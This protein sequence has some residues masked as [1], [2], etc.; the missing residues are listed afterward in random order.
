M[1]DNGLVRGLTSIGIGVAAL[2]AGVV[3]GAVLRNRSIAPET[4]E[5]YEHTASEE[6]AVVADDG[7]VLHVEIDEPSAADDRDPGVERPT[8]V[9]SHGY[10][11]S[12]RSWIFIRR[13][14]MAAGYRV[15]SWDQRGHG[16]SAVGDRDSYTIRQLGRDLKAVIDQTC[17]TG[18]LALVGHS[19]GGMTV[20]ALA[21]QFPEL[22]E[23]RVVAVAFVATAAG[24][25]DELRVQLG[26][27]IGRTVQR[28]GP[29]ALAPLSGRQ[30]TVDAARRVVRDAE[31]FFTYRYS[32][33]SPVPQSLIRYAADIIMGTPIE[34]IHGFIR[35]LGAHDERAAL[36][37]FNG[38][39]ALV[40]NG[41]KD[42][43]TPP[44]HSD[45]IVRGLPGAEHVVIH[46]CGH[47]IMLEYP[48]LLSQQL[49]SLVER[50]A[51]HS[52]RLVAAKPRAKRIV[53]DMAH[54]DEVA[55]RRAAARAKSREKQR[56]QAT[57]TRK[58]AEQA[59][60][61]AVAAASKSVRDR[62]LSAVR[63]DGSK[64]DAPSARRR[65]SD[66][67]AKDAS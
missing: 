63:S 4:G 62:R 36:A 12:L 17:P 30:A 20:M 13:E 37:A 15:V 8:V 56:A 28:L 45:A 53:T 54:K 40:I 1:A 19:M 59:V 16:R 46:D 66:R 60:E 39:E 27:A 9:L 34:V 22:V 58:A 33:G 47:L 24:G 5:D 67:P 14:L 57:R 32:F 26:D 49:I 65:A 44:H 52:G 50:G 2:G 51:R 18:T 25:P 61:Q 43:M 42:L 55:R 7:V 23:E 41:D 31:D 38:I 48:E 35:S 3:S 29:I 64:P 21:S 11:L 10:T 6:V